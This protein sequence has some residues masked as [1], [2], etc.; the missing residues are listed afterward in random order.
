[1]NG[2][3]AQTENSGNPS[4]PLPSGTFQF[5]FP[6]WIKPFPAREKPWNRNQPRHN[7][8]L[9]LHCDSM[10]ATLPP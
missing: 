7:L 2:Q 3:T 6:V 5:G 8:G 9:K 4:S 10:T 1:M